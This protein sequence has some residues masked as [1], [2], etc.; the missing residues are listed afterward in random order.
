M[1]EVPVAAIA[2]TSVL[3]GPSRRELNREELPCARL[4][5]TSHVYV[6]SLEHR[7]H[8]PRVEPGA[9]LIEQHSARLPRRLGFS[10]G[11][12]RG[13]RIVGIGDRDDPG[14]DGNRVTSETVWVAAAIE[15]LVVVEDCQQ[16]SPRL[17]V[18]QDGEAHLG[19]RPHQIPLGLIESRALLQDLVWYRELADVVHQAGPG[20]D[21]KLGRGHRQL[22]S[23]LDAKLRNSMVVA[24]RFAVFDHQTHDHDWDHPTVDLRNWMWNH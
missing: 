23:D 21:A 4:R 3:L 6:D 14:L 2:A 9:R 19:M 10:I 11:A 16:C 20:Q 13:Q 1:R 7:R 12:V 22:A 24:E 8:Y 15:T 18:A 17:A 5:R